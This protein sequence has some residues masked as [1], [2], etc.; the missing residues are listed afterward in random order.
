MALKVEEGIAPPFLYDVISAAGNHAIKGLVLAEME[1]GKAVNPANIHTRVMELQGEQPAWKL[2]KN[3]PRQFCEKFARVGLVTIKAFETKAAVDYIITELG[4]RLVKP[5]EGHLFGLSLAHEQSLLAFFGPTNTSSNKGIRPSQRRIELMQSM[6]ATDGEPIPSAR[7][8]RRMEITPD[9]ASQIAEDLAAN[10]LINIESSGRGKPT[11][12]FTATSGLDG[13]K[14]RQD[15]G[16]KFLFDVAS[17]LQAHFSKY[18]DGELSNAD[19]AQELLASGQYDEPLT[20]LIKKVS[21]MTHYFAFR[22][23]V[24]TPK[25]EV[26]AKAREIIWATPEQ[27]TIM[28]EVLTVVEGIQAPTDDYL[29]EGRHKLDRIRRDPDLVKRLV[30][31]T[32]RDSIGI[33]S[34]P[35]QQQEVR[36]NIFKLLP[37]GTAPQTVREIQVALLG[38]GINIDRATI[39]VHAKILAELGRLCVDETPEGRKFSST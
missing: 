19:I 34:T 17:L 22:K 31:K 10:S 36:N 1:P 6:V 5:L 13:M 33:K 8:G 24:L 9:H 39:H 38:R 12:T 28:S 4:E 21:R 2:H 37:I 30:S 35:D 20:G 11:I 16:G 26:S 7:L 32:R 18:P 15:V 3:G 23:K 25:R 29:S 14:L 27:L